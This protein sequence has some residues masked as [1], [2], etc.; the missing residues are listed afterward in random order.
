METTRHQRRI[1]LVQAIFLWEHQ[2][3]RKPEI[4]ASR[5]EQEAALEYVWEND[6]ENALPDGLMDFDRERFF[7][8]A[9]R[10]DEIQNLITIYA[11]EWP[12]DRIASQDR[13]ILYLSI[14][15]LLHSEVPAAVVI[16]EAV[17]LAKEFGAE[18]SSKFINGVLSS[19]NK[20]RISP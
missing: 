3:E 16:N 20:S 15:E 6:L 8:V 14:Y 17:E 11:P 12:V 4:K 9:D 19:I 18:R 10:L 2:V 7:G 1:L 13:A 5:A